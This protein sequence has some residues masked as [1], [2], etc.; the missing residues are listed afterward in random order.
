MYIK[1]LKYVH[2]GFVQ[3]KKM[4]LVRVLRLK[5]AG[6]SNTAQT[7]PNPKGVIR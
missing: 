5:L 4:G 7:N 3:T 1:F 6:T 2:V